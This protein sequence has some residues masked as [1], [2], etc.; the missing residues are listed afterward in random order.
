MC[1]TAF[2]EGQVAV[3]DPGESWTVRISDHVLMHTFFIICINTLLLNLRCIKAK[4]IRVDG[5]LPGIYAIS[6]TGQ[7]DRDTEEEL[8]SR[9]C[10]WRCRPAGSES[11]NGVP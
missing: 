6:V 11:T 2:F 5:Y 7:F 4:W 9:G 8:E 1:T 3:M 10:R